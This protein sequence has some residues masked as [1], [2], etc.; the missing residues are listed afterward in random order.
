MRSIGQGIA[1]AGLALATAWVDVT[2]G[3]VGFMWV[4]LVVWA[5]CTDW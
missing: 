4:V 3:D 5:C 2:K 1:F